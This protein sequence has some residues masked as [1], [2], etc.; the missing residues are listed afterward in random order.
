MRVTES[1]FAV[2]VAFYTTSRGNLDSVARS[3]VGK[4][5]DCLTVSH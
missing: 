3:F 4:A 1:K 5:G 2:D